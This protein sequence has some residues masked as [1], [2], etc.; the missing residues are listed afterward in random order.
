MSRYHEMQVFA[1][2]AQLGS[3]AAAARQ[4]SLSPAT[5]IR[6]VAALETRLGTVLLCRSSR[7][8]SLSPAGEQFA[9]SCRSILQEITEAERSVT[10]IH[11]HPAGQLTVSLPLLAHRK[12]MPTALEYLDAF[13]DVQLLTLSREGVPKLLE[14]GID[15]ALVVGHLCDSSGYAVP[16]GTV[17]PM[18]CG[19]PE[20][21]ATW[22][23]PS[24]PEDISKHRIIHDTSMGHQ[25][26]WRLQCPAPAR[27]FRTTPILT[28]S[29]RQAAIQAAVSGLGLTR[30][31]NYEA[32]RHLQCGSLE[33]VLQDF[34]APDLP[35]QLI[36]REGRKASARVRTFIDFAVPR[37]RLH[38]VF[39]H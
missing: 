19:S 13:P 1:S 35:V 6:A 10:G 14:E 3:L 15:V 12:F 11:T 39:R 28:C 23:R 24:T 18:I 33:P 37:L 7:G 34:T 32:H 5:I 8:V 31:M 20:Y 17:K 29:T 27:Q 22:G 16:V 25:A 2:V 9:T 30:C 4:L 36:Y 21:F 26:E 38:P